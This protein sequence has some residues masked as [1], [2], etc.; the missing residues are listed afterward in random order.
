MILTQSILTKPEDFEII[1]LS[2]RKN[3]LYFV[4]TKKKKK[5]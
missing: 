4:Y 5:E 2:N 3:K 1:L